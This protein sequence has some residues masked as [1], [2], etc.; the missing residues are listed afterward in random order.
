MAM[1]ASERRNAS[2]GV[3]NYTGIDPS[4]ASVA[5]ISQNWD[6]HYKR[7]SS[8]GFVSVPLITN[9]T[10]IEQFLVQRGPFILTHL[11][12]G[13]PYGWGVPTKTWG[14]GDCHA[15]VVTGLD[16]GIN[17][18]Q[19]WMNNPWGYKDKPIYTTD[20]ITALTKIQASGIRAAAWFPR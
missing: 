4:N 14:A 18:G 12:Q 2:F 3:G 16:S 20:I 13:F 10:E 9:A 8:F 7:L 1:V 5:N 19:C 11:C 6:D 17:G 15:V